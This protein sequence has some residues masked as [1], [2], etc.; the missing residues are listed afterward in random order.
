MQHQAEQKSAYRANAR[1]QKTILAEIV[2]RTIDDLGTGR[3]LHWQ[4]LEYEHV[5]ARRDL[6]ALALRDE[7]TSNRIKRR[8]CSNSIVGEEQM[9]GM[10]FDEVLAELKNK[11]PQ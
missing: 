8:T 10:I 6:T 1:A 5:K 3:W 7:S 11:T 2:Q 9:L 4:A